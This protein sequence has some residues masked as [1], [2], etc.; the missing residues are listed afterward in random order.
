MIAYATENPT[1]RLGTARKIWKTVD[2]GLTW[3]ELANA[4]SMYWGAVAT[5]G[6]GQIVVALG[7]PSLG[8]DQI[9]YRSL[10]AGATWNPVYTSAEQLNDIAVSASGD[11]VV[12]AT[13]VGVLESTDGGANFLALQNVSST[14]T[15]DI[16]SD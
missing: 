4:P 6:D 9:V 8:A 7:L 5:S 10:D 11:I 15:I 14:T 12:I 3:T 16:S 13:S 2:A 1:P